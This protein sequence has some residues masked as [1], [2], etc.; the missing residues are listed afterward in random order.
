MEP[1]DVVNRWYSA[2][3]VEGILGLTH[4]RLQYWDESGFLQ[5]S[6]RTPRRRL[7]AFTD[8]IQLSVVSRLLKRG[9][10]LRRIRSGVSALKRI[11]PTISLPL[12]EVRIDTDGENLFVR[13]KST[14]LEAHTGQAMITFDVW[15]LYGDVVEI[16]ERRRRGDLRV[17]K[18]AGGDG[19]RAGTSGAVRPEGASEHSD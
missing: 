16:L 11:L 18:M 2:K 17:R 3:E 1:V 10:R 13:H 4:R 19:A 15:D 12:L 14:W 6:R 9:V 7:Y 8:L 5:P